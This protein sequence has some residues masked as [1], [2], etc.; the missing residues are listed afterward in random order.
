[1]VPDLGSWSKLERMA[2]DLANPEPSALV[3][4][5][6]ASGYEPDE[7]ARKM[8]LR[9]ERILAWESGKERP[10][11]PQ[12][13]KLATI[14]KRPTASFY[15]QTL[16]KLP[17]E[18]VDFRRD[19]TSISVKSPELTFEIRKARDR[20]DWLAELTEEL[21]RLLPKFDVSITLQT[22]EEEAANKIRS[23]LSIKIEDQRGWASDYEA[24]AGWRDRVEKAGIACFQARNVLVREC[25]GFSLSDGPVPVVVTN[26]KESPRGR[27]F[28]LLHEVTHIC[29][30]SAGLCDLEDS[31]AIEAYCNRVAGAA[32]YPKDAF[33]NSEVVKTH[34]R[35]SVVWADVELQSLS[36]A[37]GGSREAA[38]VRLLTLNLTTQDFYRRKRQEFRREYEAL[39]ERAGFVPP[40]KVELSCAGG[41]F[42][43]TVL[44]S[45][46]RNNI[47]LADASSYLHIGFK[48]MGEADRTASRFGGG[49][50]E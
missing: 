31:T 43:S 12:L 33:L 36:R 44:A 46:D 17:K 20:R 9:P 47:T 1:M 24:F 34:P 39:N 30:N 32:I 11:F 29:L 8:K 49:Y 22:P 19:A 27:L 5:R 26:I 40:H 50:D 6:R 45:L 48:H 35:N 15:L 42:T 13:R 18:P 2:R 21:G 41:L 10:S 25:R 38:L 3:W 37:F 23:R 7:T 16:P 14:Y 28:T 4:A